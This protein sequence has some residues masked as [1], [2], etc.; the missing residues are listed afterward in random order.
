MATNPLR[1]ESA[2]VTPH[3]TA[4]TAILAQFDRDAIGSAIE[5][6]V[7]VLDAFDGDPDSELDGDETDGNSAE[8]DECAYFN[9][10]SFG[11]GCE[12]SDPDREHDGGE[13]EHHQWI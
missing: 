12:V 9:S 3:I 10:M 2:Q 6:L 1:A 11:P 7:G 4:L 5:V 8:D 13:E